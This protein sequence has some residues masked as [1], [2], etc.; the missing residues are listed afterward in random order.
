MSQL[1]ACFFISVVK[2]C[3]GEQ[4]LGH[5][6]KI[7]WFVFFSFVEPCSFQTWMDIS[8]PIDK[9]SVDKEASLQGR[10]RLATSIS[11]VKALCAL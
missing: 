9:D 1:K 2:T 11:C 6:R 7:P 3:A 8:F 4:H 5:D 10:D